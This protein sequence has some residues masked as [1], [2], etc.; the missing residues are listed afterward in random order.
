MRHLHP[1]LA[2]FLLGGWGALNCRWIP[3]R[4]G[5]RREE[6]SMCSFPVH[7]PLWLPNFLQ[8]KTSKIV[9]AFLLTRIKKRHINIHSYQLE[10]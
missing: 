9:K 10:K 8:K 7:T 5:K 2:L 3:L 1:V 6:S 4:N